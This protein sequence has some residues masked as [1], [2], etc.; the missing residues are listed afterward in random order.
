MEQRVVW[1]Q[2]EWLR[3]SPGFLDAA[4]VRRE[5]D[6]PVFLAGDW[7]REDCALVHPARLARELARVASDLGVEIHEGTRVDDLDASGPG[8]V[9]VRTTAG[10]VD[11][12]R[13][14]LATNVFPSLLR[15]TRLMTVPVYDYVLMTEPLSAAQLASV[16]W[17]HRLAWDF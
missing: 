5:I 15:R 11:S 10:S 14:A 12:D 9:R 8:P 2:V 1:A 6:S 13:V 16:G 17:S 4:A 3:G 7:S